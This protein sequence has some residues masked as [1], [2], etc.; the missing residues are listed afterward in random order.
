MAEELS[1]TDFILRSLKKISHKQWELFIVSR[2]IHGID[3]DIE[4]V[5]QQLVLRPNGGRALT[6][7]Y[8]PQLGIHLEVDE[9]HHSN[10]VDQDAKR[11]ED[12]V[13]AT[14]H[15]IFNIETFIN[16]SDD[17]IMHKCIDDVAEETDRFIKIIASEKARKAKLGEFYPWDWEFN[18]T[19]QRWIDKGFL[20]AKENP[21]FRT[22]AE[23]LRCFG[24]KG[25]ALQRGAW[26]IPDGST[27]VVWFPR[28]YKYNMWHNKLSPDGSR[29]YEIATCHEAKKSIES[30][31]DDAKHHPRRNTIVFAKARDSLGRNLLRFVGTFKLNLE[32]S[33]EDCVIFDLIRSR[34]PV[35]TD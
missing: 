13:L 25:K 3:A 33:S 12:I 5:C 24:F 22:Q 7:I 34:E 11:N 14:G 19:S 9:K 8:F 31:I 20:D 16:Y 1:R 29:I 6:D 30:Q 27:D 4:F 26:K 17:K 32:D 21:V 10:Q 2:V 18:F 28:L 23:A 35:R 15:K